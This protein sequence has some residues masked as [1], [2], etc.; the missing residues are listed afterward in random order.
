MESRLMTAD[1]ANRRDGLASSIALLYVARRP[2]CSLSSLDATCSSTVKAHP[3]EAV[4][5]GP[6]REDTEVRRQPRCHC[7]SSAALG[8]A[9][10]L[11]WVWH[12]N[13][14]SDQP[15]IFSCRRRVGRGLR[16]G[17][18]S[19]RQRPLD[20]AHGSRDA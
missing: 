13:Q 6:A 15:N 12:S 19:G 9:S 17:R 5:R 10:W 4:T 2:R 3:D 16:W 1:S 18:R 20:P 11:L 14:P 8:S 7:R